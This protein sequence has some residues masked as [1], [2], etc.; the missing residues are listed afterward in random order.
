MLALEALL[1]ATCPL[2]CKKAKKKKG[3]EIN[4][5]DILSGCFHFLSDSI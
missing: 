5:E 1:I 3:V 2:A 4:K